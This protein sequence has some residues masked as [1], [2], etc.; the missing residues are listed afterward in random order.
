MI[1]LS[2]IWA[3][4]IFCILFAFSLGSYCALHRSTIGQQSRNGRSSTILSLCNCFA[5]GIFLSTCFVGLMPHIREQ[6]AKLWILW[7]TDRAT[8]S[9]QIS[10]VFMRTEMIVLI[11]FLLILLVEQVFSA[12]GHHH[13]SSSRGHACRNAP[14]G[15]KSSTVGSKEGD[16]TTGTVA[17][18]LLSIDGDEEPLVLDNFDS[19]DSQ[20][21]GANSAP[22]IEFRRIDDGLEEHHGATAHSGHSH[23]NVLLASGG[24]LTFP[25]CLLLL[26]LTTHSLFE[27][28]AL[29]V[30][31]EK[32]EF[33]G[34]L[35]A[36]MLHEVLC[37]VAFGVNL[38]QQKTPIGTSFVA[39]SMLAACIPVGMCSSILVN[40]LDS[41]SSLLVRFIL[42][43]LAAGTF[44]YVACVEMLSAELHSSN[45][46]HTINRGGIYKALSVIAGVGMFFAIT[47]LF[48]GH[49]T[50]S[51]ATTTAPPTL[52]SHIRAID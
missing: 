17:T 45:S 2:V 7:R 9:S 26:G 10:R 40:S 30:Q 11:G 31:T 24:R 47:V 5:C 27:G 44:I 32:S 28:I 33:Y 1:I 51:A 19:D 29:G 38:A 15:R 8:D 43:G 34:L 4:L 12:C 13:S 50:L 49:T 35:L 42:E 48:G 39:A 14:A 46:E 36:I 6:E 25:S 18:A 52:Q 22:T 20:G 41:S 23:L 21:D 37:S 16:N 3:A